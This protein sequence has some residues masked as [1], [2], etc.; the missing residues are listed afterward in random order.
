VDAFRETA[1]AFDL[2]F[3]DVQ[4]PVLDGVE[5]TRQIRA[6]DLPCAKRIPI[7]ATTAN[8]SREDIDAYIA[9][10]MNAH[11]SKPLN[12]S[13]IFAALARCL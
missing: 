6:M 7:I 13:D 8:V 2:I 4:M 3:M 5:A 1:G 10:G 11:V 9:A 12:V